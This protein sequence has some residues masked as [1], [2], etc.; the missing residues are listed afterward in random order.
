MVAVTVASLAGEELVLDVDEFIE[1][2]AEQKGESTDKGGASALR[3]KV[4]AICD[5]ILDSREDQVLLHPED[6]TVSQ[7]LPSHFGLR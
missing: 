7:S 6:R 5:A 1:D 2:N 4:S 3:V